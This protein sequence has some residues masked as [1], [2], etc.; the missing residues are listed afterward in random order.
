MHA[1]L[2]TLALMAAP[3]EDAGE[4]L[5]IAGTGAACPAEVL[6]GAPLVL[7]LDGAELPAAIANAAQLEL[8]VD[9]APSRE[10]LLRLRT[11]TSLHLVG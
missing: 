4:V 2:L 11:A 9:V 6:A 8:S 5:L 7:R 10:E 1:A 3:L